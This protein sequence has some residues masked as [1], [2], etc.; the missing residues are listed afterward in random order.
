MKQTRVTVLGHTGESQEWTSGRYGRNRSD[1]P[2]M[3]RKEEGWVQTLFTFVS[4]SS[5]RLIFFKGS[6][7]HFDEPP[8]SCLL[9]TTTQPL[10]EFIT[11][12]RGVCRREG[13]SL[14]R[15][16]DSNGTPTSTTLPGTDPFLGSLR[17][18]SSVL[19]RLSDS[20]SKGFPP[21]HPITNSCGRDR[22]YLGPSSGWRR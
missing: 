2:A 1:S 13:R 19:G 5:V 12:Q 17:C 22:S 9:R 4:V 11:C 15:T 21:P 18:H 14:S 20:G 16:C 7:D 8:V 3:Y 10:P 6:N